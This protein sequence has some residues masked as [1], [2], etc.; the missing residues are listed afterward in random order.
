MGNKNDGKVNG[1]LN[2]KRHE[3]EL[4][5]LQA[6]LCEL[7]DSVKYKR[8]RVVVVFEGRDAAGKGRNVRLPRAAESP[9]VRHRPR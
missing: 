5:R 9:C 7:H 3:K 4:S 1:S 2:R 6:K 8:R